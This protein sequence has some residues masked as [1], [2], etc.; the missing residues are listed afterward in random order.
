MRKIAIITSLCA[1]LVL[2]VPA[3]AGNTPPEVT[4]QSIQGDIF[5]KTAFLN[6]EDVMSM[7]A[8]YRAE[9]AAIVPIVI[10]VQP[11]SGIRKITIV[12]DE[13][14]APMAAEFIF[15]ERE[16]VSGTDG[17]FTRFVVSAKYAF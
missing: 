12:I 7:D 17:D 2:P 10:K 1:A 13:N 5:E 14:P 16:I 6:G 9:D 8:P 11:D 15:G 4:W 3:F